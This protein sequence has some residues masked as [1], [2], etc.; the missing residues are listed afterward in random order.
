MGLN[1]AVTQKQISGLIGKSE[2][3]IKHHTVEMQEKGLIACENGKIK[4]DWKI[5]VK[6]YNCSHIGRNKDGCI[7]MAQS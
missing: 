3:T 7:T 2:T 5:L 4:G 6:L 1:P